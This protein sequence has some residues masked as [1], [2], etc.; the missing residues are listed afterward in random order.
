MDCLVEGVV[1]GE[2]QH[3]L[4]I[5]ETK[6]YG[7]ETALGFRES[8]P[9]MVD[10]LDFLGDFGVVAEMLDEVGDVVG[11]VGLDEILLHIEFFRGYH[12]IEGEVDHVVVVILVGVSQPFLA[13]GFAEVHV[14]YLFLVGS[15]G[16]S[17]SPTVLV[18]HKNKL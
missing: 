1:C 16:R 14:E 12:V 4:V 9:R 3:L 7:S 17:A 8:G 6:I 10:D 15:G 13:F 18:T 5:N 11:V 2:L